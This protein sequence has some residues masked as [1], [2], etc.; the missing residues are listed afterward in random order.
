MTKMSLQEIK[1]INDLNSG[2]QELDTSDYL[3]SFCP[4][5]FSTTLDH[6]FS[7]NLDSGSES[8]VRQELQKY[9]LLKENDPIDLENIEERLKDKDIEQVV[10]FNNTSGFNQD[11]FIL[12]ELESRKKLLM[13]TYW[14]NI[15]IL[16]KD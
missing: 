2:P 8:N 9:D 7:Y 3:F 1:N 10:D 14:G 6:I 12:Y 5:Y 11:G 15:E 13:I 4:I 16:F